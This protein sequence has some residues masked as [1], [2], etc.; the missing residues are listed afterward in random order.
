MPLT[1]HNPFQIEVGV[2]GCVL[3]DH[4]PSSPCAKLCHAHPVEIHNVFEIS[5]RRDLENIVHFYRLDNP[6]HGRGRWLVEVTE[7]STR[8]GWTSLAAHVSIMLY[9]SPIARI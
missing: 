6:R 7:F 1:R 9:V 3:D 2:L 5:A 8:G 4:A